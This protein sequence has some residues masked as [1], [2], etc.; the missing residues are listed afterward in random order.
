[1][2][3]LQY[4][5][6]LPPYRR[7]GLPRYSTDLSQELSKNNDVVLLYPG[8]IP[9]F[10][11][12]KVGFR[13]K[14]TKYPFRVVEMK[15]PLPVSLG[16]G[17]NTAA[18]YMAKRNKKDIILFL[19]KENPD[20]IH[21]HSL[22]GLPL[23]FLQVAK[24]LKIK[25]IYTTHD[26]YGL[27][28]KM[29]EKTPLTSLKKRECTYDCMLCKDGPSIK[30]IKIMQTHAYMHFKENPI[31]KIIRKRQKSEIYNS[32]ENKKNLLVSDE[33]AKSRY[34]LRLYYRKMFN[35]I[36]EFHF[37][38]NVSKD[39]IN[40]FFP[41]SFGKVVN[42]THAGL[43]DNRHKRSKFINNKVKLGYV[44]PYDE[45]KGFFLLL[46]VLKKLRSAYNNFEIHFYGDIL[47]ESFFKKSWVYNHGVLPKE[48]MNEAYENID[49]LIMPSLWHETFGFSVLE[50][51]SYGDVCLVSKNVGA[52]D[53][54][55][56]NNVFSSSSELFNILN[57]IMQLPIYELNNMSS[58]TVLPLNFEQHAK[59]IFNTFYI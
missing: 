56:Q 41:N 54:V 2:K 37:N 52:K 6:G 43:I 26:F 10:T 8:T 16:L 55:P 53:L 24:V 20:V 27:C 33:E 57:R 32:I 50:A 34:L 15:N 25:T 31:V 49:I 39:Y 3:I 17:I 9:F 46:D 13:E 7:G 36:S 35:L 14:N 21:I 59:K 4:T 11:S 29:L 23:E 40:R 58:S 44:G 1:M 38:S 42:I 18:P 30:K 48:R 19:K 51:L 22:M 5:L 28:P 12:C 45:K 47:N